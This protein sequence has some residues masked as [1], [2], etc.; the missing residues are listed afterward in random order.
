MRKG[1]DKSPNLIFPGPNPSRTRAQ[2][3]CWS[4]LMRVQTSV[5]DT[6]VLFFY[7]QQCSFQFS[8]ACDIFEYTKVRAS[9]GDLVGTWSGWCCQLLT[10][11][12]SAIANLLLSTKCTIIKFIISKPHIA[13]SVISKSWATIFL[14]FCLFYL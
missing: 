12:S 2:Q 10:K 1:R 4:S 13:V 7:Y 3:N 9:C 5:A 8:S 14:S 6:S 11:R